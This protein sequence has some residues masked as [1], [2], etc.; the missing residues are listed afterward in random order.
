MKADMQRRALT[1]FAQHSGPGKREV[2][3]KELALALHISEATAPLCNGFFKDS[4]WIERR[5][6]GV[7]VASDALIDYHRKQSVNSPAARDSLRET[8]RS[9]WYWQ[10]L[11]PRLEMG[12]LSVSDATLILM[13]EAEAT[14]EHGPQLKNLL[15]W[16]EWLGLIV[17]TDET[18]TAAT[19]T[20]AAPAEEP[21]VEGATPDAPTPPVVTVGPETPRVPLAAAGELGVVD[22][23]SAP[24]VLAFNFELRL[25]ATALAAL[26]AEQIKALFEAVGTIASVGAAR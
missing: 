12:A 26:T 8:A 24:V 21:R 19:S 2:G 1:V 20:P 13:S 22:P 15:D 7:Y 3:A 16:M 14:P 23:P 4:G 10:A 5:G 17:V 9:A 6:K 18:V 11:G 25:T